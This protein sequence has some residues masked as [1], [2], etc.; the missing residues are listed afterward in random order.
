LLTGTYRPKSGQ[1]LR[2][3]STLRNVHDIGHGD[4]LRRHDHF[5][6]TVGL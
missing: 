1:S 3:G 4:A 6:Q 5:P 2:F